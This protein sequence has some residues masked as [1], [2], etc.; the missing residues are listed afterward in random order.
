MA[1]EWPVTLQQVLSESEFG[2]ELGNT[3][4]ETDMDV[5]P[6]K[7]RRR[8]TKGIDTVT[9]SI[10][11][12]IDQYLIF[13]DFFNTTLNGG[14]NPFTFPHPITQEDTDFRFKGT[15]RFRSIGGGNFVA[16]FVWMVLP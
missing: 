15:P 2:L 10:Y 7:S 13:V 12:T 14:T 11:L 3:V 1:Q 4:L 16:Q 6:P 9:G 5:G 8:V